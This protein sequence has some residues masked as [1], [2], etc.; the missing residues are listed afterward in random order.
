MR[1]GRTGAIIPKASMSRVMVKKMNVA[2][3]R[4]PLGGWG[5]SA[6]SS[7]MSSGSVRSGS[8]EAT[9]WGGFWVESG[10]FPWLPGGA[11]ER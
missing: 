11:I 8:G 10:M 2:A 5:V 4:R 9:G 6:V 7:S 1:R 3:A